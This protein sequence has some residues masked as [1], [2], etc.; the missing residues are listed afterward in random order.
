MDK[1]HILAGL[2][3][4][5]TTVLGAL[6]NQ[7]P[8]IYTTTSSTFVE[9]L[10]R[11]YSMWD[12]T[13][14]NEIDGLDTDKMQNLKTPFLKNIGNIFF[15]E[16]TDKKIV[17]DKRRSWHYVNNIKMYKDIYGV[18]PKIICT[19]RDVAEIV[20]S[21]MRI[22]KN[23]DERF[24]HGESLKRG[25]IFEVPFNNLKETF[26]SEY[27]HC[28]HLVEYEDLVNKPQETLNKIYK[29]LDMPSF[30]HT[31]TNIKTIEEEGDHAWKNLHKIRPTLSKKERNIN[32]Y[33][34]DYEVNQYNKR[35]FWKTND[36]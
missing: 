24:I 11:N 27:A 4:S 17:I 28:L 33:L 30:E 8:K 13:N 9:F 5:G 34:T 31:F 12:S 1:L 15:N 26:L 36:M 32:E 10:W 35:I 7:N 14:Y 6:L 20:A 19:V 25:Q 16:L 18:E 2:P 29:F 21:Y 3:R 23:N 22:F